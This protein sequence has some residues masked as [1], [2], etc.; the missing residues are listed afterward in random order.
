MSWVLHSWAS[1]EMGFFPNFW[2]PESL[3]SSFPVITSHRV[4]QLLAWCSEHP[5]KRLFKRN[6]I[7]SKLSNPTY[8]W[9]INKRYLLFLLSF[10]VFLK[11]PSSASF[12]LKYS[13]VS[14]NLAYGPFT[15]WHYFINVIEVNLVMLN[16]TDHQFPW[17]TTIFYLPHASEGINL[18][19]SPLNLS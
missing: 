4:P 1:Q 15:F 12:L 7:R 18:P 2:T 8:L 5:G 19:L 11:F 16:G 9:L 6:S 13:Q 3:G 10:N 14:L 17:F